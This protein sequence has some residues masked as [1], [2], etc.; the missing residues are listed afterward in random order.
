MRMTVG[1]RGMA[2]AAAA[3]LVMA[4]AT[5]SGA[6]AAPGPARADTVRGLQWYLDSLRISQ[7]QQQSKGRGVTVAVVDSGVDATHPELVGQVLQGHA[8]SSNAAP[9]GRRDDGPTGHG[10]GMAG[11]I[12]GRGGSQMRELG[13]APE[14]K[15]LPIAG[16][17]QGDS[18]STSDG[19][20]WAA[21][22]GAKV[23]NLSLGSRE[24]ATDYEVQAVQYALGKDVVLVAAAGNTA[25]GFSAVASPASIPGVIAVSGTTKSGGFSS[26]SV[27]G[28][29]VVLA[30]PGEAIIHPVP[31]RLSKNGYFVADG[32]SAATAIVSGIVALIRA[33]YPKL[34]A[35]NVVNRLIRTARDRGPAGRDPQYGFGLVDPVAALTADVPAVDAN[36]LVAASPSNAAAGPGRDSGGDGDGPVSI[37]VTNPIGAA[38]QVAVILLVIVLIVF[39]IVRRRGSNRRRALAGPPVPPAGGRPPGA[40]WGGSAPAPQAPYPGYPPP[41]GSTG[42]QQPASPPPGSAGWQQPASPAGWQPPPAAPPDPSKRGWQ[43]PT[44]E[45]PDADRS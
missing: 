16:G 15:I 33:K 44:Q 31:T 34:T 28:P 5:G 38:I 9:D 7:A 37:G 35:A 10:T 43:P 29:E 41:P 1:L 14:A 36:P 12:A 17:A 11:I 3:V 4:V 22:H 32:T 19:I 6:L 39:F 20:R 26:G 25:E 8:V 45:P 42:W 40:P 13:I 23:I 21:D 30:A 27:Q 2:R 18:D 24:A